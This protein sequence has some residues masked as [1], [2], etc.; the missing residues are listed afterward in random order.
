M[1][2][3][4]AAQQEADRQTGERLVSLLD[5]AGKA[6]IETL[7]AR[8]ESRRGYVYALRRVREL[9]GLN[10][11]DAKRLADSLAFN[12]YPAGMRNVTVWTSWWRSYRTVWDAWAGRAAIGFWLI[13]SASGISWLVRARS[14]WFVLLGSVYM[15]IWLVAVL[16]HVV[17]VHR[18]DRRSSGDFGSSRSRPQVGLRHDEW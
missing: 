14:E 2:V 18:G 1:R 13:S 7:L 6:E 8:G 3:S 10:L 9:T 16:V 12:A 5:P 15:T 17:V 11:I 4:T